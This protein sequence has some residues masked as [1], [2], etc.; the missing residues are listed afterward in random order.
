MTHFLENINVETNWVLRTKYLEPL[1]NAKEGAGLTPH[2][3]C[4][5]ITN[6]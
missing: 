1:N 6:L 2:E 3:S 4:I 5:Y